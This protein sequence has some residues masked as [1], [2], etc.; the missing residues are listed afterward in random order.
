MCENVFFLC[1]FSRIAS[2]SGSAASDSSPE[3][4]LLVQTHSP[5]VTF[6]HPTATLHSPFPFS[7]DEVFCMR[8]RKGSLE[9]NRWHGDPSALSEINKGQGCPQIGENI[10][11][12]D[13]E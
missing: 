5:P 4:S 6:K 2:A 12:I 7:L 11:K 8:F 9:Y 1:H 13:L 10:Q 3:L